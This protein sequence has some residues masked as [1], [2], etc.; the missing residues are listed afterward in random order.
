MLPPENEGTGFTGITG[1]FL[2]PGI[3]VEV[4][5][6]E[7]VAT[8]LGADRSSSSATMRIDSLVAR[9]ARLLGD[10]GL[11]ALD[12]DERQRDRPRARVAVVR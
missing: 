6:S 9:R 5:P 4:D 8:N 3:P 10:H 7:P 2:V 11:L 1:G 12:L